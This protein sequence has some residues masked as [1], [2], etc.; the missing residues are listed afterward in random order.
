MSRL[1]DAGVATF[2]ML[3]PIF[4]GVLEAQTL[5]TLIDAVNPQATE[6]FWAEPFNDRVNWRNV[7]DGYPYGSTGYDWFTAVYE[8]GHKEVWSRYA[9]SL[10]L[11][12]RDKAARE[13]WLDKL[14][15][16]LYES[17]IVERDATLFAGLKEVSLQSEKD[18]HGLSR[19][20]HMAVLQAG[21]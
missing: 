13:G 19:N 16:L 3:C 18:A 9:T 15:Y 17:Q 21:H 2:G 12:L 20:P 14:V 7:R 6:T 4:P 5:E 8:Q 11:R 1:Q 10:Y